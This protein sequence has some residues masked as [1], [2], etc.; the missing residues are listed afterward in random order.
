[1]TPKGNQKYHI[2]RS[3]LANLS[4]FQWSILIYFLRFFYQQNQKSNVLHDGYNCVHQNLGKKSEQ[5]SYMFIFWNSGHLIHSPLN[6]PCG[7][8]SLLLLRVISNMDDDDNGNENVK[9]AIGLDKQNN[10][11]RASRFFVHFSAVVA[12]LQRETAKFHVLSRTGTKGNNYIF[13]FLALL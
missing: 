12:R 1:M 11:A 2:K 6:C 9:K 3:L 10:F 4:K 8:T 5:V 7:S 13:L